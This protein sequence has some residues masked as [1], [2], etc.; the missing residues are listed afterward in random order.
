MKS[1]T[2]IH[3]FIFTVLV[4]ALISP[5]AVYAST[6]EVDGFEE[7][8]EYSDQEASQWCWAASIQAVLAYYGIAREQRDIVLATYGKVVNLPA[9]SPQSLYNAL[10]NFKISDDSIELVRSEWATGNFLTAQLLDK[11]LTDDHPIIAWFKNGPSSGHSVVIYS[12]EFATNGV[13]TEVKYFDPW[14]G[15]GFKTVNAQPFGS[16]IVAFFIVKAAKLNG[17]GETS[18]RTN[19]SSPA[20]D[21]AEKMEQCLREKVQVC[22]AECIDKYGYTRQQCVNVLCTFDQTNLS[23]WRRQCTR[24]LSRP[25]E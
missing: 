2:R 20:K 4:S 9:F 7:K 21:D 15:K 14:P 5:L 1:S 17:S 25:D 18:R 8:V 11:E 6:S 10:N 19:R 12:A 13:P 24:Q 23:I 22:I 16:Q 3:R